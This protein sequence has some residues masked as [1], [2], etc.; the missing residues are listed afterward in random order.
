M[1]AA[2]ANN[3]LPPAWWGWEGEWIR[4]ARPEFK[5]LGTAGTALQG[6]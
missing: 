2:P 5:G 6:S 4:A 3:P 1:D